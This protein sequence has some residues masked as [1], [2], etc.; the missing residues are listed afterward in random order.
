MFTA[1]LM[2]SNSKLWRYNLV[3]DKMRATGFLNAY[4]MPLRYHEDIAIFYKQL[5]TYNPQMEALNGRERSHPQGKGVHAETNRCYGDL[6]R[7]QLY[8][9]KYENLDKKF[10]RSIISIKREHDN[11]QFH[12]TQKPVELLEYLIKTYT[13]RDDVVLD[14]CMGSGTTAIACLHTHRHFIGFETNKEYFDLSQERIRQELM[15]PSFDFS[16]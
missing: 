5:P 15:R 13:N 8:E 10:P 1:K 2:T 11:M 14:N 12:P 7:K 6:N 9:P 3:W 16:D 4:K